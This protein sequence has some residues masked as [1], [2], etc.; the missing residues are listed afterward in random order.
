MVVSERKAVHNKRSQAFS[1]PSGWGAGGGARTRDRRIPAELRADSL[2]TVPPTPQEN[3]RNITKKR[4]F[5]TTET[6][7]RV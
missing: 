3:L 5:V 1:P 7:S 2:A 4:G 6:I